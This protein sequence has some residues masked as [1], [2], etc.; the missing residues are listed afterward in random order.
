M[1]TRMQTRWFSRILN[2]SP[3]KFSPCQPDMER[4]YD[5]LGDKPVRNGAGELSMSEKAKQKA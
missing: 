1:L 5:I 4:E 3:Q 2:P